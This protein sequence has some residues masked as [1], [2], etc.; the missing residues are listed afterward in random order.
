M[1]RGNPTVLKWRALTLAAVV[2]AV[3]ASAAC[4]A[5]G[6]LTYGPWSE[7]TNQPIENRRDLFVET[8][9]VNR[10]AARNV[11]RYTRHAVTQDGLMRYVATQREAPGALQ[12]TIERDKPLNSTGESGG[13][14]V[15]E[16]G[17]FNELELVLHDYL[18]PVTQYRAREILLI[19]CALKPESLVAEVGE[20][21]QLGIEF[22]EPGAYSLTSD[23]PSVMQVDQSGLAS[24][25]RPGRTKISLIHAGQTAVCEVMVVEG[26]RSPKEGVVALRLAGGRLTLRYKAKPGEITELKLS[27]EREDAKSDPEMR[28]MATDSDGLGFSLR[29]LSARIAYL[30]APLSDSGEIL[31]GAATISMLR[32]VLE[33]QRT[34]RKNEARLA[35]AA[36]TGMPTAEPEKSE[37]TASFMADGG[38]SHRFRAVMTSD[39]NLLLCLQTDAGYALTAA[40]AAEGAGL[41]IEKLDL[42]NPLQRWTIEEDRT[43]V[44]SASV[45]RLPV[46]DNSFCQITDDFKTVARDKDKH[47]GVDFSPSGNNGVVAVSEGRVIRVDARCTHD[48]RKTKKNKYGRYIDPCDVKEGIV[49]KY[50]SYGKYVVIEHADGSRSMYAHLAKISVRKGQ[51]VKRGQA[52]G[53]MGSTGSANGTHLHFEARVSGRAVDPRYFLSLPEIGGYVP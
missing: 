46:A 19:A 42:N 18:A 4:A 5:V 25:L 47:D 40:A 37:E 35:K 51:K 20:H 52:I 10:P 7:W 36:A 17:W 38:T 31:T 12:Q 53:A 34:I 43:G 2:M 27:M 29:S 3:C 49:S 39:N 1:K 8:R 22:L 15:Y 28:V 33:L 16:G 44:E 14:T 11:W 45:W 24:A 23:D 21:V 32:D 13:R 9:E 30:T 26:Y 6:D 41:S 48:Y 50:G